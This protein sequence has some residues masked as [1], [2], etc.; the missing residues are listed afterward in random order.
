V[1]TPPK[2]TCGD[3]DGKDPALEVLEKI[4]SLDTLIR[5]L[6][7]TERLVLIELLIPAAELELTGLDWELGTGVT[8]FAMQPTKPPALIE[9]PAPRRLA[10]ITFLNTTLNTSTTIARV[11]P[12]SF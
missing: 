1:I 4:C 10:K 5:L 6:E 7:L 12:E 8:E 3:V 11:H 2:E 9:A